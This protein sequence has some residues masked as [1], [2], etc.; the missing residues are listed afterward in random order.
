MALR[1]FEPDLHDVKR[2]LHHLYE[3]QPDGSF[4]LELS[5]LETYVQGLKSALRK[6]RE[7]VKALRPQTY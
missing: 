3:R 4:M 6:E 5:D 7:T 2:S 1:I